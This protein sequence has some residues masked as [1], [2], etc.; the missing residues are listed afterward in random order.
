MINLHPIR[1]RAWEAHRR[2]RPEI[3]PAEMTLLPAEELLER[4]SDATGL[5]RYA[6]PPE[7]GL[8]AG[9][10]AVLLRDHD[11]VYFAAPDSDRTARLQ[12]FSQAHEFAHNWLHATERDAFDIDEEQLAM[13]L[14]PSLP[15]TAQV[16]QGY[17]P[18]E[19]RE[20]E[21]NA[22]A[23]EFLLPA[24]LLRRA[25]TDQALGA[26][27]IADLVGVSEACVLTQLALALLL[28]A[29]DA[30]A[31]SP[32]E[33]E[34]LQLDHLL[35]DRV[36]ETGANGSVADG[37]D[38]D[39]A[40]AALLPHGPALTDAGPG[41]GKTRT[42]VARAVHLIQERGLPP[43][44]LLALTFSNKAAEEMRVR[45]QES[46][47]ARADQVWIGTFHAFGFEIL[48]KDGQSLGL[49]NTPKLLQTSD[50]VALLVAHLDQLGLQ[51]LEYLSDPSLP[52]PDIL[53]CI[54]RAKDECITP[55]GYLAL[56]K[57]QYATAATDEER[58]RAIK[59]V[60]VAH[61][62]TVYERLKREQG[63]L[64]FG[65][66]LMRAVEL[67]DREPEVRARWQEQYAHVL[68]DE[69]QDVNRACAYLLQR[70]VGEGKGFWAVGDLRQAIYRFRGASPANVS[71]FDHD[72]PGGQRLRLGVN[73]RSHAP[74]V[75]LFSG[76][77]SAMSQENAEALAPAERLLLWQPRRG[78]D[79]LPTLT[80]AEAQD[81]EGQADGL[82]AQI[83]NFQEAGIRMQ[84]QAILV[85][86]NAQATDLAERLERRGIPTQHLGSLFDRSEVKDMLALV[87]LVAEPEG[88][89]LPRVA[90]FAEYRV[91]QADVELLL[92][93]ARE[94]KR[95]FPAALELADG[96]PGLSEM[97][98]AGLNRL[99]SQVKPILY[100][101]DA[102]ALLT[103]Y[104]F[105]QS[106]YLRPLI[107]AGTVAARQQLLALSQLLTFAQGLTD[108]LEPQEG[109][110]KPQ[111][112]LR[113]L[114][115]LILCG[116]E[117][118]ART[119]GGVEDL[120]AV[121]LMTVHQS[122]GLE[123]PVVY[124]PNLNKGQFPARGSGGMVAPPP[125]LL[126]EEADEAKADGADCLFFVALSRAKD[127]L[128]L[129]RPLE[130]NGTATKP[131][132]LLDRLEPA[133]TAC[134]AARVQWLR[135]QAGGEIGPSLP[136]LAAPPDLSLWQVD[137]YRDCPRRFYYQ[138]VA[139]LPRPDDVS[140]YQ[141]F[142]GSLKE[143]I[144]WLQQERGSGRD[145]LPEE[146]HVRL[147]EVWDQKF[148]GT[149][150][151]QARLLRKHAGKMLDN[152]FQNL[153]PPRPIAPTL[154]L[155]AALEH[156]RVEVPCD[157][158][159]SL[160]D[161]GLRVARHF[162]RRIKKD[163]H[164]DERLALIR[165]AATQADPAR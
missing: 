151:A 122:K 72:F 91:P 96:L 9:A 86:T 135:V 160:P 159:E 38:P 63:M 144:H 55:E 8:L 120:P 28:P 157:E 10:R 94:Q 152:A 112:F 7:D 48:R 42:L 123:F 116:E 84:D 130:R 61:V 14:L 125:A 31:L 70:L 58:M 49:P 83:L 80:F 142:H 164:T 65:D 90:Q 82:C 32:L 54:S 3:S 108:R 163:D 127:Q 18:A 165:H 117:R 40:A 161:G 16:A 27:E 133:L 33:T 97:G 44:R 107:A 114:R 146:A 19:R 149:E 153:A 128:V 131:S 132:P 15:Q 69:Y 56:A 26:S 23:A 106:G 51:E 64:D 85:C 111:L 139:R 156:G 4:A 47:G 92:S 99:W 67:L 59:S 134:G 143:T 98:R 137:T 88:T 109:E 22:F 129:S 118:S 52:L 12:R 76:F 150:T 78:G 77:A 101:G 50:A 113:H 36:R 115:Q 34:R 141:Q 104:L 126:G 74:I 155:V 75:S 53:R 45:L 5:Q 87:A 29:P 158:A 2:L 73:Y 1:Q 11:C 30:E 39:Q 162:R 145:P 35:P 6:L 71:Q 68:A 124:L 62:Y 46:V 148:P 25:F 66:L 81:E 60:E 93:I 110:T 20:S 154:R 102:W 21:A 138:Q 13:L 147:S 105:E 89:T 24:P 103:R 136:D 17:S 140:P 37:L 100:R 57:T 95:S 121:R 43:E 119:P 79:A 41:T